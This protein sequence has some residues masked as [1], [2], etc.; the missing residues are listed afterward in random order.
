MSRVLKL[1]AGALMVST[2]TTSAVA[3]HAHPGGW[4]GY[5]GFHGGWRGGY[6]HGGWGGLRGH[7]W[8]GFYWGHNPW[9]WGGPYWA[10]AIAPPVYWGYY[11]VPPP[12]PPPPP[13]PPRPLPPPPPPTAPTPPPPSPPPAAPAPKSFIVYFPFDES[14]LTPQAQSVVEDA[15]RYANQGNA[16]RIRVIGYTDASGSVSYN[17]ALSEKRAKVMA[18]A[19]VKLGVTPAKMDVEWKGKRDLAVQT[20]DGVREPLNRRSTI[21]V[22]F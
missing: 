11:Q 7:Y 6:W 13:A 21:E 3:G 19:L 5:H 16:T 14:I 2:I 9:F 15:A 8:G 17:D 18:D 12:P 1:A 20:G 22:E 4:G 10:P